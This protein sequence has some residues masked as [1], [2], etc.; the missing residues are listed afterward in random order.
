MDEISIELKRFLEL[1]DKSNKKE[2]AHIAFWHK[3][4]ADSLGSVAKG[5]KQILFSN[6]K[7][8]DAQIRTLLEN[9][10]VEGLVDSILS[11]QERIKKCVPEI[12]KSTILKYKKGSRDYTLAE[13]LDT[14]AYHLKQHNKSLEV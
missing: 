3:Y 4:Y 5:E 14:I 2:L 1:C 6:Y 13:Y 8:V 7:E 12:D 9:S 11:S 10:T